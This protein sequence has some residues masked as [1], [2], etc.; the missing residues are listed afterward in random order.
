MCICLF[1]VVYILSTPIASLWESKGNEYCSA[2]KQ[3]SYTSWRRWCSSLYN[4]SLYS[5]IQTTLGGKVKTN[6]WWLNWINTNTT[7]HEIHFMQFKVFS[8]FSRKYITT[9]YPFKSTTSI[10]QSDIPHAIF[11]MTAA[12]FVLFL[13]PV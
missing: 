10:W 8:Y 2:T 12:H 7:Q 3:L 13:L 4:I 6:N 1:V 9:Y 11:S 5:Y